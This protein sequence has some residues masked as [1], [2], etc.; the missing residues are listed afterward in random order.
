MDSDHLDSEREYMAE[1]PKDRSLRPW[2]VACFCHETVLLDSGLSGCHLLCIQLF[3]A[4]L[5][6]F[7]GCGCLIWL[8]WPF[9]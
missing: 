2:T 1:S 4:D 5:T 3:L 9:Q 6:L 7:G 8:V